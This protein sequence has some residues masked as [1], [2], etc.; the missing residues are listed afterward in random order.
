[1]SDFKGRGGNVVQILGILSRRITIL[2]LTQ[3]PKEHEAKRGSISSA[4]FDDFHLGKFFV[5]RSIIK[6]F[7]R[8]IFLGQVHT[9]SL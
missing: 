1:M 4:F 5:N 6:N 3:D 9:E 7:Q 8:E 2:L